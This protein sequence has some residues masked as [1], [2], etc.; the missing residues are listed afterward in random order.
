MVVSYSDYLSRGG[1]RWSEGLATLDLLLVHPWGHFCNI[2]FSH[3]SPEEQFLSL[4][5][6]TFLFNHSQ[7]STVYKILR[8]YSMSQK[9]SKTLI[10]TVKIHL[11][12][13][14]KIM[15]DV[16]LCTSTPRRKLVLKTLLERR[17]ACICLKSYLCVRGLGSWRCLCT[18]YLCVVFL[19]LLQEPSVILRS[20][21]VAF[22]SVPLFRE[23]WLCVRKHVNG[24]LVLQ[25]Y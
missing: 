24:F 8:I 18:F 22:I 23:V 17:H 5:T 16:L 25:P 10:N 9:S 21:C 1:L 11:A 14:C 13:L 3:G 19:W 15:H 12:L 4:S 6:S 20:A 7:I 2:L